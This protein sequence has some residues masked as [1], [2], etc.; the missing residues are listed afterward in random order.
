MGGGLRELAGQRV[1]FAF[2]TTLASR[3][4]APW[5]RDLRASGYDVQLVFLWLPS[6]DFAVERVADRVR[7]GGHSVPTETVRRRYHSGLRNFFNLY[8]ALTSAW[9]L[10]DTSG[11]DPVLVA[12]GLESQPIRVYDERVWG[13]IRRQEKHEG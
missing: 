11:P 9:R 2:E 4:L 5:L 10:Y 13:L 8:Q 6:A 12:D 7:A 1:S 3:T